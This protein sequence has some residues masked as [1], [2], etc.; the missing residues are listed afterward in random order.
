MKDL[1][2]IVGGR[3]EEIYSMSISGALEDYRAELEGYNDFWN[4]CENVR[5]EIL[6]ECGEWRE[7]RL[8]TDEVTH[9]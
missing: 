8:P 9:D 3:V 4:D 7:I 5:L 2:R 1:V 6:D